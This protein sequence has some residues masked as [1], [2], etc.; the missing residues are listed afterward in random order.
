MKGVFFNVYDNRLHYKAWYTMAR[1]LRIEYSGAFYHVIQRGIERKN[2]FTADKDKK[3]L[4]SCLDKAHIAYKALF[5][6]YVLMDNHYHLILETPMSNL[7]KIMHYVNTSYAAYYNARHKRIGPLYQGRFKA[8]LVQD[9]GYLHHLSRYIHLNPVRCNI[10]KL[11]E[12][13]PWSS[14][15]YFVSNDIPPTWLNVDFI[16]SLFNGNISKARNMYAEFVLDGIG[17][18]KDVISNNTHN[19]LVLG[20]N[21]FFEFVKNKFITQEDSYELPVLKEIKAATAPTLGS[22]KKTVEEI[23]YGNDKLKRKLAIYLSRKHT[24]NTLKQIA[25]FYGNINYTGVSQL[26]KRTEEL[27]RKDSRLDALLTKLEARI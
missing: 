6:T 2:I 7:S 21:D 19:G 27:K 13:Y 23:V 12:E 18:E 22:I 1:Q 16:L 24:H 17:S 3:K 14:Y 8:I 5:H 26:F 9:D 11:P 4:L 25:N 15:R 20:S 10:T